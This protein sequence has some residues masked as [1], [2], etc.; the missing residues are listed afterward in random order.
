M[1]RI[2]ICGLTRP[3]DIACVNAARPD[4]CGFIADFPKSC[5]SL[6]ANLVPAAEASTWDCPG[7]IFVDRP[8]EGSENLRG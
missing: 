3:C 8:P 7:E 4:S 2:K 1:M 5:R 6:T